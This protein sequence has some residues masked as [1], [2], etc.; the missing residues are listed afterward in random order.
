[1]CINTGGPI[2][3][4]SVQ[5]A[6]HPAT[7]KGDTLTGCCPAVRISGKLCFLV[8]T[9]ATNQ[10]DPDPRFRFQRPYA[11]ITLQSRPG[12]TLER[13]RLRLPGSLH[14]RRE[15]L[16]NHHNPS[17]NPPIILRAIPTAAVITPSPTAIKRKGRPGRVC[18]EKVQL[19]L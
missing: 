3:A 19:P 7:L 9:R 18:R 6:I 2:S 14:R 11:P 4:I 8:E 5:T 10:T 1:M 16:A 13:L 12:T 15:D 17:C